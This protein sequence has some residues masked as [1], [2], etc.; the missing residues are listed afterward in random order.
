[1]MNTTD[2]Q[3]PMQNTLTLS[4]EEACLQAGTALKK[5]S[6][7][8]KN[9]LQMVSGGAEVADLALQNDNMDHLQKS[10]GLIL[11]NIERLKRITMDLCEYSKIRP[12]EISAF[13]LN[14]TLRQ[15]VRDLPPAMQE[16]T[17]LLALQ[18]EDSLPAARLEDEAGV[19]LARGL[20][21]R[22]SEG[23]W[24]PTDLGRRFLNDLQAEFLRES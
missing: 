2:E 23:Q 10:L 4:E 24:R 8:I 21:E 15:A 17:A 3:I 7:F 12:L 1:M 14:Q 18:T 16:K 20:I 5:L 13:D 11:P 9:I 6:H 22:S 19:A